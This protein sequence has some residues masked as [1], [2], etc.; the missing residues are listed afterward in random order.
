MVQII[1][2]SF[3]VTAQM[4]ILLQWFPQSM[5]KYLLVACEHKLGWDI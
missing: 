1:S 4:K 2:K 5:T 3:L